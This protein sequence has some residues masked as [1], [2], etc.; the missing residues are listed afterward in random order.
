MLPKAN[1]IKKSD[2]PT[3]MKVGRGLASANFSLKYSPLPQTSQT[4]LFS[5][6]V[7]KKVVK[8]AV[9]RNKLKRR[10]RYVLSKNLAKIE[11]GFQVAIFLRTNLLASPYLALEQE[12]LDLLGR[13]KL[14][15]A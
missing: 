14:F 1:R 5:V 8:T 9:G 10:A 2:F 4:S 7:A 13:A 12:L 3:L 6:I 15:H 11:T